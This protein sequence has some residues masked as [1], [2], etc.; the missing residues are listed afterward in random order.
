MRQSCRRLTTEVVT[1]AWVQWQSA[2]LKSKIRCSDGEAERK[3][4][5][6]MLGLHQD[7]VWCEVCSQVE[8]TYRSGWVQGGCISWAI[9]EKLIEA[10]CSL[11]SDGAMDF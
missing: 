6:T 5:Q 4:P 3:W 11:S 8:A 10:Q 1:V 2:V 7:G 9:R